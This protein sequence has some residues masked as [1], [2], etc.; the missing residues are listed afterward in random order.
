VSDLTPA[1]KCELWAETCPARDARLAGSFPR[2][3]WCRP[4]LLAALAAAEEEK[5]P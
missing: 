4:C 1:R 3:H 5:K 2:E